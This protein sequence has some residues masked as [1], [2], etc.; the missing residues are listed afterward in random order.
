MD[1]SAFRQARDAVAPRPC[2]FE[3]AT[4][5]GACACTLSARRNIAERES[6]ACVGADAY[7]ECAALS[8]LLRQNAAF[9]LKLTQTDALLPHAKAMKL[10]CGGLQGVQRVLDAGAGA[11]LPPVGAGAGLEGIPLVPDVR[12]LVDAARAK[13]DGLENLPYST[14]IQSVVAYQIRRRRSQA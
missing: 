6:V 2:V 8:A 11:D 10:Q 4:L 14:I 9:A 7:A 13:F 1:E 5:S 12:A 3:K